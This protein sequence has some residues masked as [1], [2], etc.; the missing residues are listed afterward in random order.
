MPGATRFAKRD[1]C[2]TLPCFFLLRIISTPQKSCH[3]VEACK[4]ILTFPSQ[5]LLNT[6]PAWLA[7]AR[8]TVRV[9]WLRWSVMIRMIGAVSSPSSSPS[10]GSNYSMWPAN[11]VLTMATEICLQFAT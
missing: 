6:A 11:F 9:L 3:R 10:S 2:P 1:S 5:R 8:F 4:P 7:Y